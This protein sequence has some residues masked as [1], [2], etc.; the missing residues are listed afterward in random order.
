MKR[1]LSHLN[2]IDYANYAFEIQKLSLAASETIWHR[3]MQMAMGKMTALENASMWVEKPT[4]LLGSFEKAT[5]AAISGK[6]PAQ[7]MRA[8]MEPLTVKASANAK[9]LRK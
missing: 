4:A 3:S 1:S 2:P 8:A 9:R 7:I 5:L 6:P